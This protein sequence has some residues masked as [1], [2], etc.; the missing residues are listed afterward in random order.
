MVRGVNGH[1]AS[2]TADIVRTGTRHT[3]E[4]RADFRIDMGS[5]DIFLT[6][7]PGG[8]DNN[9]QFVAALRT[10][11]GAQSYDIPNDGAAYGYVL[12]WCRP[13]RVPIGLG[14]LR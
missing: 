14:E 12:L 2:G 8:F 7:N 6:R 5:V 1:S 10:T 11:S 4:L 13:F 3:L 9:D